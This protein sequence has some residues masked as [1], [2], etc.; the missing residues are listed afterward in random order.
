[1]GSENRSGVLQIQGTG[2][3]ALE[4]VL[5]WGQDISSCREREGK[6]NGNECWQSLYGLAL[7]LFFWLSG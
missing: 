6:E 3:I 2:R 1:M 5:N 4:C 7:C